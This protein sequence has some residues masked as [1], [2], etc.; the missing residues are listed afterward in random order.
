MNNRAITLS[1]GMAILAVFFVESYVSS[2]EDKAKKDFGSQV[3]VLT[4]KRDIKEMETIDETMLKLV[5][6]PKRFLEPSSI[7]YEKTDSQKENDEHLKSITGA[8]SMIPIKAGEQISF[9]KISE[10]S[11]KTGLS[12]QVTPGRR[13]VAVPVTEVSGV[14]KLVK[15]GDRVD[16]ITVFDLNGGKDKVVKTVLQDVA[17]LAVGRHV[18]NNIPRFVDQDPFSGKLRTKSLVQFDGFASVT[19]EVEPAQVQMIAL[20]LANQNNSIILSLRNNDD[21]DRVSVNA[22]GL[23]DVLNSDGAL[24]N[25][26][27]PAGQGR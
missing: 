22:M 25:R 4:A 18:T 5:E 2:I 16:V 1:L 7:Y 14:S 23:P 17:V 20:I 9:N 24:L 11:L 12:P 6:L 21:S 13:A 8:V 3:L 10:P 26:R 19:L 27:T 15:P